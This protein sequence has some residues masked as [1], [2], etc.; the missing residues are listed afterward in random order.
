MNS[1]ADQSIRTAVWSESARIHESAVYSAQGQFEA[2]KRWHITHWCLGGFAAA[3]SAVSG[4]LTFATENLQVLAG[5]LAI[6][7][8]LAAAVHTTM[9]PDKRAERAQVSGNDYTALRN[10]VRQ[11]RDVRVKAD[12]VEALKEEL[13]NL[14]ARASEIDHRADPIPRFA[15]KRAQENIAGGGQRF[16]VDK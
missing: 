6:A 5:V 11:F 3:S 8:A 4:V 13:K 2:A 12:P 9:T 7:A 16:E 15:Y 14:A 1:D 10:D